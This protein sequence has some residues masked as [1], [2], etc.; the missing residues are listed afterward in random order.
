MCY[1]G[2]QKL[3]IVRCRDFPALIGKIVT[4]MYHQDDPTKIKVSFDQHW[5]GY[6]TPT[7][8]EEI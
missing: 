4:V 2:G 7:Q 6:F 1:H 3:K 5:C 8:L